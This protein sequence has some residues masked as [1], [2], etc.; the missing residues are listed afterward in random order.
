MAEQFRE[1]PRIYYPH[2]VDHRGRAYPVPQLVNPQSDAIGRSPLEFA[3]GKPLGERGPYW[4][5]VHLANCFG[6]N[7]I[8]FD[9]RV[10]WVRQN[11]QEILAFAGHPL[12]GHRFWKEAKKPWLVRAACKEWKGYR[13][14]GPDFR[15]HLVVS[16]DGSC[17][18]YQHLSAMGRDPIGG[19]AT[20]LAPGIKPE[21][22]YQEV[23]DRASRRLARD[24]GDPRCGEARARR[25]EASRDDQFWARQLLGKI[26]RDLVKPA[27]MTTPY[28]VTRGTIYEELLKTDAIKSCIN[29]PECARY[30]AKVLEESIP[31]VAI[32]AGKIMVWLR[33]VARILARANRPVAWTAPTGF[34]VVHGVREPKAVRVTTSDS[35]FTIYA[36]DEKRKI[37][38]RKQ[39]DGIVAHFVHSM[40]AAHMM[41][42]VNRLYAEGIRHFAMV[43]DSF[44]VHACDIDLLHRV[45][46]EEFVRIY[47]EPVLQKF[48]EEQRQANPDL[49]LPEPP[50]AGDLDIRQVIESPYFFA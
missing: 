23:A 24:A 8:S 29:P 1:H 37:D 32:E 28:G 34:Y 25:G 7:R 15:S 43:H 44:G 39:V 9:E 30:L 11:E 49:D 26:D 27:T 31:E 42:T 41:L 14:Q 20:N 19:R 46:R 12:H 18:G 40:D 35:T 21:D 33:N 50:Q 5:A 2:Q 6:K 13:E 3:D 10:R 22:I 45:L 16:M 38:W 47:S 36:D 48:L 4:L 17:N